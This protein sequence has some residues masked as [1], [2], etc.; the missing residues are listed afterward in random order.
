MKNQE[1]N[2]LTV[3]S[4]QLRDL[5]PDE[6][7]SNEGGVFYRPWIVAFEVAFTDFIDG[8]AEGWNASR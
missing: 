3:S 1:V 7:I 5:T 2:T 6:M 8:V 4:V